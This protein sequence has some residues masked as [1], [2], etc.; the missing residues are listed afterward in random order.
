MKV[1]IYPH[2]N[3]FF[4]KNSAKIFKNNYKLGSN[5][6]IDES[7]LHFTGR[8]NMKFY[9]PMKPHKWG[10]KIHLLCDSNTKYLYNMLF[11]QE[12]MEKILFIMKIIKQ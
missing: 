8:N 12:K 3:R 10:F 6:T 2:K 5:I 1:Q 4:Y 11:D 9:I 7:L